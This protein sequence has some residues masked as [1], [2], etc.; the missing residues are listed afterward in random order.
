MRQASKVAAFVVFLF[1]V[2]LVSLLSLTR[3]HCFTSQHSRS[4]S[5]HVWADGG[6]PPPPWPGG[7]V[8]D[9]GAP[10]PPWPGGAVPDGGAPPPPWPGGLA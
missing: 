7:F 1:A 10:P 3:S 6:A 4:A 9:G 5:Q 8:A 2:C